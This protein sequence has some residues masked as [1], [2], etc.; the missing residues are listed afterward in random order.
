MA[1]AYPQCGFLT[2]SAPVRLRGTSRE[3]PNAELVVSRAEW[4]TMEHAFPEPRGFLRRHIDL[5]GL[6]GRPVAV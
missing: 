3:L 4:E 2:V 6:R 1:Q 5:P